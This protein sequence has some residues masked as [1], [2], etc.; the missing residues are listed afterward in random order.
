M[1]PMF[2]MGSIEGRVD[3]FVLKKEQR[4]YY[5]LHQVGLT[6][7]TNAR[8][9]AAFTDQSGN[10]RSSI[11][12]AVIKNGKVVDEG[13]EGTIGTTI[14]GRRESGNLIS[15]LAE[16]F[17]MGWVLVCVA[18]ME[19]AAAVES[20][21]YDVITGSVPMADELLTYLKKELKLR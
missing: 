3:K 9:V 6:F 1:E 13:F 5:T 18:G 12:Y 19:Y 10:L 7:M 14:E 8:Q 20:K 4:I 21:G 16:E 11:G 15:E 2:S 17:N